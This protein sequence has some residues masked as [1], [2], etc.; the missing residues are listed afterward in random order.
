MT[1]VLD[2]CIVLDIAT[3]DRTHFESSCSLLESKQNDGWCI[4]PVTFIEL[5]P[6]YRGNTS[7]L[8]EFLAGCGIDHAQD[9]MSA[10]TENA[11]RGY[12]RY[13]GL[14]R[15]GHSPKRPVADILIGAFA[16]RFQGLITRNREDFQ[17]YFA[18]LEI[19]A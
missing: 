11:C 18:D 15:A 7:L 16:C 5:A 9:W 2:T 19:L 3:R 10:D 14:K 13:I 4:A 8:R 17:A 6:L 1:W 12:W